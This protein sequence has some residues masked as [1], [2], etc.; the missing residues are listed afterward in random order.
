M[1]R[2]IGGALV[3][4]ALLGR[5]ALAHEGGTHERGVV[6]EVA[7]DRIVLATGEGK[8]VSIA[9]GPETRFLRG[10][11]AVKPGDVHAGERAVV[12]ARSS[13]GKLEATEVRLAPAAKP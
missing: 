4:A 6:K 2:F 1:R 5:P 9:V 7:K 10:E 11:V 13:D 12:H 8:T 3:A